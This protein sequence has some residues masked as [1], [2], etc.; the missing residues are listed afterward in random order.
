MLGF[1]YRNGIGTDINEQKAVELYQKAAN[2]GSSAAQH[3]LAIMY[4]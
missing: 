3:N 2:L 1:C 4:K